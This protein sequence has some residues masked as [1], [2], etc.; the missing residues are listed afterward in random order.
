MNDSGRRSMDRSGMGFSGSQGGGRGNAFAD[1]FQRHPL[2][3]GMG[4]LLVG[5]AV[6]LAIPRSRIEDEWLGETSDMIRDRFRETA[7]MLGDVAQRTL[8]EA[9]EAARAGLEDHGLTAS[10][11]KE[12]VR[13]ATEAA[14][15]AAEEGA[16]EAAGRAKEQAEGR[17]GG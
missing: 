6:G 4:A 16:R 14:R 8:H 3:V 9:G 5:A 13:E 12:G 1:Y 15:D 2:L 7:S 10:N 11:L 17:K